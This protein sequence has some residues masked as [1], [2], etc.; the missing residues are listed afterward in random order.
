MLFRSL[1]RRI[2]HSVFFLAF[3]GLLAFMCWESRGEDGRPHPAPMIFMFLGFFLFLRKRS[4]R[5]FLLA[6]RKELEK[7]LAQMTR[8]LKHQPN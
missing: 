3:F 5:D 2:F 1:K 8:L 7:E 4:L 6:H